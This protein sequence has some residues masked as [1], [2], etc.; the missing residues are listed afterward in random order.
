MTQKPVKINLQNQAQDSQRP[1]LDLKDDNSTGKTHQTSTIVPPKSLVEDM[2][3][4]AIARKN[5]ESR[6]KN[7]SLFKSVNNSVATTPA[8]TVNKPAVQYGISSLPTTVSSIEK[9]TAES[10]KITKRANQK[11]E[12]TPNNNILTAAAI[13]SSTDK[14]ALRTKEITLCL[15]GKIISLVRSAFL[16]VLDVIAAAVRILLFGVISCF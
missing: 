4:V 9:P 5:H 6:N 14:K 13:T 2:F 10:K 1:T 3:N 11:H 16:S 15:I 8:K 7:N 12:I